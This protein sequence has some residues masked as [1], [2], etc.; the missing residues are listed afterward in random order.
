MAD[1]VTNEVVAEAIEPQTETTQEPNQEAVAPEAEPKEESS[2]PAG[3][4]AAPEKPKKGGWV[5]KLERSERT[6]AELQAELSRL[7]QPVQ[8]QPIAQAAPVVPGLVE[9]KLEDFQ[10]YQEY[11][12]AQ[13]RYE[14]KLLLA[15]EK[16][17]ERK[18]NDQEK[19]NSELREARKKY[20]DYDEVVT[21]YDGFISPNLGSALMSSP[22]R[23][24]VAYKLLSDP[25]RVDELNSLPPQMIQRAI[26]RMELD[27]ENKPAERKAQVTKAPPPITPVGSRASTVPDVD[28]MSFQEYKAARLAGQI[29]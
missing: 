14:A 22:L 6:I 24:D 18:Q 8:Q 3:Q 9:P 12:R 4:E 19:F 15:E 25:D 16:E 11:T 1:V 20:A 28:K 13:V 21:G 17:A 10:N 23:A 5:R 2:E 29:K 27:L 26:M 7:K